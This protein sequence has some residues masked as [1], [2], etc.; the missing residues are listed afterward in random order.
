MFLRFCTLVLRFRIHTLRGLG[1]IFNFLELIVETLEVTGRFVV[2]S[3]VVQQHGVA[4]SKLN[5]PFMEGCIW[6]YP[7]VWVLPISG[8]NLR[9]KRPSSS[10]TPESALPASRNADRAGCTSGLEW[11]KILGKGQPH[12]VE[13]RFC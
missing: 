7:W 3:N 6:T 8:R 10:L 12:T 2:R 4:A 5:F 1:Y 11:P 9:H 13:V